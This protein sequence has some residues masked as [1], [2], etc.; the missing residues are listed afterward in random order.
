MD[1]LKCPNCWHVSEKSNEFGDPDERH[2]HECS[3]CGKTYGYTVNYIRI[4]NTFA[5][6]CAN[7]EPHKWVNVYGMTFCDYCGKKKSE[8][9]SGVSE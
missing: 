4:F 5:L 9:E 2:E 3:N 8:I 1:K 6:P 7:G